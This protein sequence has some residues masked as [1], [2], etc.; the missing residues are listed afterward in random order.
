MLFWK[1]ADF[2]FVSER[3]KEL[4]VYCA[5]QNSGDSSLS[6]IDHL[7]Y[8]V[9]TNIVIDFSDAKLGLSSNP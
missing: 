5:P 1:T 9:A 2:G 4:K 8:C 6:C 7:H 3:A